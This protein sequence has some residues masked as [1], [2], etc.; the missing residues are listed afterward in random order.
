MTLS[1]LLSL[2]WH[3][4]DLGVNPRY[5][6]GFNILGPHPPTSEDSHAVWYGEVSQD[7]A[8]PSKRQKSCTWMSSKDIAQEYNSRKVRA[9]VNT[10]TSR[11]A[12][13]SPLQLLDPHAGD[14]G[15]KVSGMSTPERQPWPE[16]PDPPVRD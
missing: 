14:G 11:Q 10:A 4:R 16:A 2:K 7:E 9:V 15:T 3:L 5:H 8:N 6:F 1:G 12:M 13:P